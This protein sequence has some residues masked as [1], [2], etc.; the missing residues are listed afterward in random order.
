[1]NRNGAENRVMPRGVLTPSTLQTPKARRTIGIFAVLA[2]RKSTSATGCQELVPRFFIVYSLYVS[3]ISDKR[4]KEVKRV[5]VTTQIV[6]SIKESIVSGQFSFGDKLPTEG[7]LCGLLKASRS[8]IREALRQ[9]QA[10][11]YVEL[12]P[13][14]GAFVRDNQSHDY[15]TVRRWF[16][17]ASPNLRDFTEVREALEPLAVRMAIERGTAAECKLL[18]KIHEDFKAAAKENNISTLAALDEKFH[19]QIMIMAHNSL[20]SSISELL[21]SKLKEYRIRSISM[22]ESSNNTVREHNKILACI[23]K[24]D[25]RAATDAMRSHLEAVKK[26]LRQATDTWQAV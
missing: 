19:T 22:K 3:L 25:S 7:K 2:A 26:E 13:G 24:K 17:D 14:R 9:L 23:I 8:S 10:E 11:G 1:M 15:N 4:M 16:V 12:L 21:N 5:P 6:E 18:Q 20:L